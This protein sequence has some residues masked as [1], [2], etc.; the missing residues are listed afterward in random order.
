VG[1]IRSPKA[2]APMWPL[3][4][5]AEKQRQRWRAGELVLTI[6]GANVLS[7]FF[8]KLPSGA[9]VKYEPEELEG[10]ASRMG[11]MTP[12]PTAIATQ[13]L[14]SPDWWDRVIALQFFARKGTQADVSAISRLL[15]DSHA[16]KGKNWEAGT[17]VGKVAKQALDGLRER[18]G[19]PQ[20]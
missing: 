18:L 1:D 19:Q 15:T 11:Q 5:D 8:A 6:G 17:T 4:Q 20:G 7:E 16:A 2:I 14:G 3:V 10:Y 12:L 9:E 13:Q